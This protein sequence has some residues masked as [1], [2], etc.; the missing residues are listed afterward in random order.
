MELIPE[1][2]LNQIPKLY[3]TEEQ[4]NPVARINLRLCK[5]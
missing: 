5:V 3:E 2:L 1:E 4:T